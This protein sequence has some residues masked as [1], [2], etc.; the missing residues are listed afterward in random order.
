MKEFEGLKSERQCRLKIATHRPAITWYL[1]LIPAKLRR[2]VVRLS[3]PKHLHPSLNPIGSA[4]QQRCFDRLSR[5]TID[6]ELIK[7][8]I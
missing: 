7:Q 2:I 1:S 3:L 6:S 4:A 5:T 8:R